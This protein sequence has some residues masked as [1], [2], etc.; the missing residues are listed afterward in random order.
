MA[1][2]DRVYLVGYMDVPAERCDAVLAALPYHIALTEAES[3]CI[4]FSVQPDPDI[5]GRLLVSE[6]FDDQAAFDAH[7]ARAQVSDWARITQGIAR[8]YQVGV[9]ARPFDI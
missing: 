5:E 7:Q 4:S 9:G 2:A 8:H 6:V 1:V 3:G